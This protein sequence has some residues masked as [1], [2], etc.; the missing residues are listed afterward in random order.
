VILAPI[1][2]SL[3]LAALDVQ[4]PPYVDRIVAIVGDHVVL[5]SEVR[6]RATLLARSQHVQLS[7]LTDGIMRQVTD[8]LV[9]ENLLEAEAKRLDIAVAPEEVDR[10]IE[11]LARGNNLSVASFFKEIEKQGLT[12]D[13]F[14][15][16]LR[17]QLATT[18]LVFKRRQL[19]GVDEKEIRARY[20]QLKKQV[21]DPKDLKSYEELRADIGNE[22]M[23]EHM[24][25]LRDDIVAQLRARTYVE[26]RIGGGS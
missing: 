10:N 15:R 16:A 8:Q 22:L 7:Q 13:E 18:M 23:Q 4:P 6:A 19:Q 20:E 12:A 1:I 17:Q 2:L 14:K 9:E 26:V 5:L 11:Q 24:Q 3:G 21:K 25:A